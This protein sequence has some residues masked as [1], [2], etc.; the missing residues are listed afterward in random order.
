MKHRV[1]SVL[2]S[3]WALLGTCAAAADAEIESFSPTGFTKDVRQVAVRFS[4]PMV[5]LGDPDRRGPFT[6]KCAIPGA[7]RWIDERRWVYDFEYEVPGA[8]RCTFTLRRGV[9]TLAGE[10]IAGP[11]E[12]SFHTGGPTIVASR[13]SRWSAPIDERQV[14]LLALDARADEQSIER[15]A[16]C[17]VAGQADIGVDVVAGVKRNEIL[18]ALRDNELDFIDEL[19]ESVNTHLPK[20]DGVDL[21]ERAMQRIVMVRCRTPLPNDTPMELVWGAGVAGVNGVASPKDQVLEFTVRPAFRANVGCSAT[22]QEQCLGAITVS[23]TAPVPLESMA[24]VRL[25]DA[26]GVELP[27]ESGPQRIYFDAGIL[28]ESS[29]RIELDGPIADIDGRALANAAEFPWTIRTGRLHPGA[30]LGHRLIV[31]SGATAPVLLRRPPGILNGRRLGVAEEPEI[32]RWIT[33]TEDHRDEPTAAWGGRESSLLAQAEQATTPFELEPEDAPFQVAGVPLVEPGLQVLELTLP[34]SEG[35]PAERFVAGTASATRLAVHFQLGQESSLVWVTGLDD[36]EP[37]AGATVRI[38]DG[39]TGKALAEGRSDVDGLARFP[40]ALPDVDCPRPFYLVTARKDGDLALLPFNRPWGKD[41]SHWPLRVHTVLDRSLFQPG[42]TV[43]M[44]HI[45]R[46]A[47]SAG[48]ELPDVADKEAVVTIWHRG[49]GRVHEETINIDDKG[50]AAGTFDL[51]EDAKLGR[52]EIRVAV[53]GVGD[54]RARRTGFRVE[55]FRVGALRATLSAPTE[56]VVT[57]TSVT[58]DA[59]VEHLAGGG[60]ALLPVVVRATVKERHNDDWSDP[61]PPPVTRTVRTTLDEN[62]RA[63]VEIPDIP[64]VKDGGVLAVEMDYR[65]DNGEIRTT[66]GVSVELWPAAVRLQID[67]DEE[68]LRAAYVRA[69]DTSGARVPGIAVQAEFVLPKWI[70]RIGRLPGGFRA[71]GSQTVWHAQGS[72]SGM[73]DDDG[74]LVCTLPPHLD[75]GALVRATAQ[76]GDGNTTRASGW[77]GARETVRFLRVAD[78]GPI[79]PGD[80]LRISTSSPEGEFTA[81][82]TVQREGILDAFVRRLTGPDAVVEVPARANYAPNV[83]VSVLA[84]AAP[85]ADTPPLDSGLE[86]TSAGA[87]LELQGAPQRL[88]GSVY[89]E[90]TSA[91]NALAVTVE[92]ERKTYRVRNRARVRVRVA[93]PAGVA[94]GDADVAIAAVD[95]GLLELWPNASWNLLDAMMARRSVD[96]WSF[97]SLDEMTGSLSLGTDWDKAMLG[98]EIARGGGLMYSMAP[99]LG[100]PQIAETF[101]RERFEPLLLWQGRVPMGEDG[102]V[103]VDVPLNDLVTSFRIVAVATAGAH[104]FGT[105]DATIRTTQDLVLRSGL[106]SSVREGDRFNATFTVR[107]ATDSEREVAVTARVEGLPTLRRR[108][109]AIPAGAS[110]EAVWRVTVP[111]GIDRLDWDVTAETDA[112]ADRLA[113]HQTVLPPVPVQVQQATLVQ[114]EGRQSLPVAPPRRALPNRGGVAVALRRSIA[115][116]LDAMR[117]YMAQYSYTCFEQRASVAVALNDPARWSV[118]MSDIGNSMD[119]EGLVKYFP[120]SRLHGSPVLTAYVLT[121]ADAA[122]FEIPEDYRKRMT[123][124]LS[125]YLRDAVGRRGNLARASS[126]VTRLT[127]LAALARHDAVDP[128]LFELFRNHIETDLDLNLLPTSALLDWIDI[129]EGVSPAHA[130]L[131]VAKSIIRTR[132]DLQGTSLAFSTERRDRLWSFM[133]SID[134][135]AARTVTSLIADPDWRADMPRMMRGLLG[136]QQRGRWRTTVANAWGAIAT[137][138]FA[139]AFEATPVAGTSVVRLGA[140]EHRLGWRHDESPAPVEIP[141][142]ATTLTLD[143]E[144]TGAPW[145]LVEFRAAVPRH[146]PVARGYRIDRDV[147]AIHR[148]GGRGWRRGDVAGVVLDIDA[149]RDMTWVVVEDPLPPGAVVLGSGLGGDSDMLGGAPQ[150]GDRWPVY[151]ERDVDS[152]RAYYRYVPKGRLSLRYNVRYNTAGTFTLPPTRVEAMYAPEM[153][154]ERP[155]KPITIR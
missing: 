97:S 104:L 48:F 61:E 14:F 146:R 27:G 20:Q 34:P 62:G 108:T 119:D 73:T 1:L 76:D 29:Y 139:A 64:R 92:P 77:A 42:Q 153:H 51:P 52:Y 89:L 39:C 28:E 150:Y 138:R 33:R 135:N 17:R 124:G 30:T 2:L 151:S 145:G 90:V 12:R 155:V 133:V 60:A 101:R 102:S 16:R 100:D 131:A 32:A 123:G 154:A 132:L 11:R 126:T 23:F 56:P 84:I 59:R 10:A 72:C 120:S 98:R 65:D 6:V 103:E 25:L 68:S 134:S 147:Q 54:H 18:D 67:D 70:P 88:K 87:T 37:V 9:K 114:L 118:L 44:K 74:T 41:A 43:S 109:L 5:D 121:I 122:G 38:T 83:R 79:S 106:V 81:L 75:G 31:A 130:E 46:L 91:A 82:V 85:E 128:W 7:G 71:R 55:R 36:A 99:E 47:T 50:I 140:S 4:A 93:D 148:Q 8:E 19:A 66:P 105:G 143:H 35:I 53:D 26:E 142:A 63:R 117:E 94:R 110:K 127:A 152:Y 57:P 149:D 113:A 137:A 129:L 125:S 116:G 21:R 13:A 80:T 96:V 15:Y 22:W 112:D 40:T 69:Y 144:G 86:T 141:W 3:W 24:R 136:R 95:Q 49:T 45:L 78:D 115:G 107:N 111:T 58:I